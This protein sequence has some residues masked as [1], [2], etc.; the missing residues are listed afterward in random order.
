MKIKKN[1]KADEELAIIPEEVVEVVAPAAEAPCEDPKCIAANF[2]QSAIECLAGV[3]KDDEV[4]KDSIV[5]LS[6]ILLDL[7]GG[8]CAE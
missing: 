5:N 1:V 3:A 8:C 2:I 7:K 4:A 6:V